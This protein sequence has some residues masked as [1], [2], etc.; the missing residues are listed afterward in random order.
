MD[1]RTYIYS[2]TVEDRIAFAKKCDTS[3][4][5]LQ[6]CA[7]GYK[8]IGAKLAVAIERESRGALNV[9][10]VLPAKWQRVKDKSWPHPL[11]RPLLDLA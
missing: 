1:L 7:Y 11:G 5:H 4:H 6:N 8:P 10:S 9:D 3:R 2:L